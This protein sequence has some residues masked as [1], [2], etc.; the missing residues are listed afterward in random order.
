MNDQ[1]WE[2]YK[3]I[4]EN[5]V[6]ENYKPK[7]VESK[8][9]RYKYSDTNLIGRRIEKF[10]VP[11]NVIDI[12]TRLERILGLKLSG[13]TDTFTEASNLI[14]EL[15]KRGEIQNEQH[16]RNARNKFSTQ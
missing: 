3:K 14:D 9:G 7:S 11:S 8:F 10:I 6:F 2:I 16:Y 5:L 4:L 13:Q 15:Y 1:E 12:Y